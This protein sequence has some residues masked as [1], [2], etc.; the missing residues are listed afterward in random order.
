VDINQ[1]EDAELEYESEEEE[2][3]VVSQ[4]GSSSYFA[5]LP[6]TYVPRASSDDCD[7]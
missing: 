1:P 7:W 5:P 2:V 3:K 6:S 4:Y